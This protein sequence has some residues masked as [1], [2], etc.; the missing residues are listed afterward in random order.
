MS[1]FFD[2]LSAINDP[3]QRGSIDQ[4]SSV[5]AAVQQLANSQGMSADQMNAMLNALGGALQPALQDQ[6]TTLGAGQIDGMLGKLAR[7]GGAGALMAM[8]PPQ[9]KRQLI[10]LI[11]QKSSVDVGVAKKMLPKLLSVVLGLL[12]MGTA[13]SGT[14]SANPLLGAFL[15]S[16]APHVT[17]LGTVITY[18]DRFLNPPQ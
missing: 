15:N 8:I 16:D 18:A 4:L 13:R 17:D 14:N 2:V 6:S 10:E 7:A 11:A 9:I 1:L 12:D 3:D 5:M